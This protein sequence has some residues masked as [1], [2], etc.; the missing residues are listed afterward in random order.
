VFRTVIL[1]LA[2]WLGSVATA[3]AQAPSDPERLLRE[4]DRAYVG[5]QLDAI[6]ALFADDAV[7]EVRRGRP[8]PLVVGRP[9][10]RTLFEGLIAGRPARTMTSLTVSG[11]TATARFEV[12]ND[13]TRR[14]GVA[15]IIYTEANDVRGGK[16]TRQLTE[17]D[18][19][20][21]QTAQFLAFL[22][23]QSAPAPAPATPAQLPR[24]GASFA[25]APLVGLAL[26]GIGWRIRSASSRVTDDRG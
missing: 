21:A 4:F 7:V 10:I 9:A 20:D 11:D 2:I 22:Q 26:I 18:A 3:W 15:R 16:I 6:T 24:T 23:A 5:G 25:L 17:F 13:A 12:Q 14:A 19:T 1:V 8:L